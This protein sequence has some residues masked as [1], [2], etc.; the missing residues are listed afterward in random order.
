MFF[1]GNGRRLVPQAEVQGQV[2]EDSPLVFNVGARDYLAKTDRR[3]GAGNGGGER[4]RLI[5]EK[6]S[7]GNEIRRAVVGSRAQRI[8]PDRLNGNAHFE[9]VRS[10]RNREVVVHLIGG[11]MKVIITGRVKSA[12]V[13]SDPG[14]LNLAGIASRKKAQ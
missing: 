6:G 2:A 3:I 10:A 11:V 14:D 9:R 13:L 5:G 8:R 4:G 1:R 7:E 12:R